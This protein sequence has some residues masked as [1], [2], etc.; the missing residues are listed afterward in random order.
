M[1]GRNKGFL[2]I[3]LFICT[4]F[5]TS[6][7]LQASEIEGETLTTQLAFTDDE[8][9]VLNTK[10]VFTA[11]MS[12]DHFP[13][14]YISE[15]GEQ[16]GVVPQIAKM[17]EEK[18]NIVIEF[19]TED[20]LSEGEV[21]DLDFRIYGDETYMNEKYVF[22]NPYLNAPLNLVGEDL[23][24]AD[25][26]SVYTSYDYHLTYRGS[27]NVIYSNSLEEQIK[28][29]KNGEVDYI[30]TTSLMTNY[31]VD[32][33]GSRNVT[34][35]AF[36]FSIDMRI[37]IAKEY[38]EFLPI[39]NKA[40]GDMSP[41]ILATI[42][43]EEVLELE[44]EVSFFE[45]ITD[46]TEEQ[47]VV[48]AIVFSIIGMQ[49][50]VVLVLRKKLFVK[51]INYDELTGVYSNDYFYRTAE[52]VL[53]TATS[54]EYSIVALDVDN[55]SY[56]N[57]INGFEFGN[58]LLKNI[59]KALKKK[60]EPSLV[61]RS[62][63]DLFLILLE[64][65]DENKLKLKNLPTTMN[66]ILTAQEGYVASVSIGY[67]LLTDTSKSLAKLVS[68]AGQARLLGKSSCQN[69]LY[70]YTKKMDEVRSEKRTIVTSM[71]TAFHN[72]EFVIYVSERI[73]LE[74]EEITSYAT[75]VRW[76]KNGQEVWPND[77][78]IPLFEGNTFIYKLDMYVLEKVCEILSNNKVS[79]GIPAFSVKLSAYTLL[80]DTTMVELFRLIDKY[81]VDRT[82]IVIE[83]QEAAFLE[84]PKAVIEKIQYMRVHGFQVIITDFGGEAS[85]VNHLRNFAVDGIEIDNDLIEN[86]SKKK[87]YII[88]KAII[89]FAN[90]LHIKAIATGITSQEQVQILT[91]LGC[92]RM[93]GTLFGKPRRIEKLI[94]IIH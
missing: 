91:E 11:L 60:F 90:N 5:I 10:R 19:Y 39:F 12:S 23:Y 17:L 84:N 62:R 33:I 14:S 41:S 55:F 51:T 56:I 85:C 29:Y 58:T 16:Q 75:T 52:K 72:K 2:T 93:Q 28:K 15:D 18:L 73:N 94:E 78:F 69:T 22:T 24:Q 37:A 76:E 63:D 74:L 89:G 43:V 38:E 7:S 20:Q 25:E 82:K 79:N 54:K 68:N 31:L 50:V 80:H 65:T 47:A 26:N 3:L 44:K 77:K 32:K 34:F 27:K 8:R 53:K 70:E 88:L 48:W 92:Y 4:I 81:C 46:T 36:D 1:M 6:I 13:Y 66:D 9:E 21:L 42:E 64:N 40:I 59:G 35:E 57:E 86:C 67:I 49:I 61:A 83:V 45:S 71:Q 87:V 30:V